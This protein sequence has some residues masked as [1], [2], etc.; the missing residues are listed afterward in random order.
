M[1]AVDGRRFHSYT[2]E[3]KILKVEESLAKSM[4]RDR[5]LKQFLQRQWLTAGGGGSF[6]RYVCH[7]YS[8]AWRSV[9]TVFSWLLGPQVPVQFLEISVPSHCLT[10]CQP[11]LSDHSFLLPLLT[12]ISSIYSESFL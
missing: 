2:N 12:C 10:P 3:W 7:H 4:Q 11:V 1:K 5:T 9:A 6:H 8:V